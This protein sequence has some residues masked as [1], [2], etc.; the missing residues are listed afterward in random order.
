VAHERG[1]PEAIDVAA[2]DF[3]AGY[4]QALQDPRYLPPD[5]AVVRRLRADETRSPAEFLAWAESLMQPLPAEDQATFD[6]GWP[7]AVE[8][9]QQADPSLTRAALRVKRSGW[10]RLGIGSALSRKLLLRLEGPSAAPDDDI[11]VEGKEVGTL[12]GIPCL[13]IPASGEVFR[14]IEGMTQV[15]RLGHRVLVAVP[16]FPD[17]RPDARGWWV[18][19]WEPTYREVEIA[20]LASSRELAEMAHDVGAQLG[21]T[22]LPGSRNSL[23]AQKRL[24]ELESMTR[25]EPRIRQVAHDLATATMEAW[26]RFR[27]R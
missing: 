13:T 2:T 7:K 24:L 11:I 25:L 8:Y 26:E 14:V 1:W 9:A 16:V 23:D 22:N 20:D 6:A 15:G 17:Q 12:A 19:T 5:P 3:L 4:R 18:K 27:R 21:S 10:L